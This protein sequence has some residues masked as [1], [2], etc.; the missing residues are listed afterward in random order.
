[1]RVIFLIGGPH[2]PK[3]PISNHEAHHC[4]LSEHLKK[5]FESEKTKCIRGRICI[6]I[7]TP[8]AQVSCWIKTEF[9]TLN[10]ILFTATAV[11]ITS[12][13]V[14]ANWA[15][16]DENGFFVSEMKIFSAL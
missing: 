15:S 6:L 3:I 5:G 7:T 2:F 9:K 16:S 12:I 10:W 1:M 14:L 4:N 8:A 11:Q 13:S